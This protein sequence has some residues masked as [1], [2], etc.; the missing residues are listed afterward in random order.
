MQVRAVDLLPVP[1]NARVDVTLPASPTLHQI[2]HGWRDPGRADVSRAFLVLLEDRDVQVSLLEPGTA[3]VSLFDSVGEVQNVLL[4][5]VGAADINR[6]GLDDIVAV[7]ALSSSLLVFLA[8][9]AGPLAFEPSRA[10]PYPGQLEP[11]ALAF[12][13]AN[14]DTVRDVAFGARDGTVLL[15]AGAGDGTFGGAEEL[16]AG[17]ELESV[18]AFDLDGD[19]KDEILAAV[20]VPGLVVLST[21]ESI[22]LP[23][24]GQ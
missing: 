7:D 24:G 23:G 5:A 6:D 2:A 21:L 10:F 18:R 22:R 14:G 16:F 13:D 3:P 12:L 15:F 19:G 20:G 17:P 9:E 11:V 1:A 8:V 4:R